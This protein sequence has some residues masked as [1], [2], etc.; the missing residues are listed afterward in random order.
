MPT[1]RPLVFVGCG[2][3]GGKTLRLARDA[4]SRRLRAIGWKG[5]VPAAWQ[6]LWIDVPLQQ[7]GGDE[8][9]SPLDPGSYY[10]LVKPGTNY[11]EG[12]DPKVIALGGIDAL[13][14]VGWRPNPAD[15]R[16]PID[17]AAGEFRAV[18]RMIAL[19]E[20]SGLKDHL[21]A[22]FARTTNGIARA[23]L[24]SLAHQ[25]GVGF[26]PRPT[27]FLVSSLAGGSGSGMFLDV[28]DMIRCLT[29]S[30]DTMIG[31]FYTADAFEDISSAGGVEPN[32]LA[33]LAELLSA[34]WQDDERRISLLRA[35][36]IP[37][38]SFTQGGP[39]FP[40]LVGSKNAAGL[41][42]SSQAEVYR[43]VGELLA[44]ITVSPEVQENLLNFGLGNWQAH[45]GANHDL[46]GIQEGGA[47]A[48]VSSIGYARMG[49][50]RDRFELYATRRLARS[51]IEFLATGY[52]AEAREASHLTPD[53]VVR[54]LCETN[55]AAFLDVC[56]LNERDEER[57]DKH[58]QVVQALVP[59]ALPNL[60]RELCE[61]IRS[62][63]VGAADADVATWVGRMEKAAET[64]QSEFSGSFDGALVETTKGWT[65][66]APERLLSASSQYV[67]RLGIP[68]TLALLESTRAS[69]TDAKNQL[70]VQGGE[71]DARATTWK[72]MVGRINLPPNNP[73][74]LDH[75]KLSEVIE[76]AA[77]PF[78]RQ[79]MAKVY[80]QAARLI[81]EFIDEVLTPLTLTLLHAQQALTSDTQRTPAGQ[82]P[83]YLEWP[84]RQEVPQWLHPSQVEFLLD[85]VDQYPGVF[86]ELVAATLPASEVQERGI[87]DPFV[88]ARQEVISGGFPAPDGSPHQLALRRPTS[89]NHPAPP[90][91]PATQTGGQGQ[92]LSFVAEFSQRDLVARAEAWVRRPGA[93]QDYLSQSLIEYLSQAKQP[94][95]STPSLEQRLVTLEAKLGAAIAAAAPLVDVDG[96]R[97]DVAHSK[98]FTTAR[99][100]EP[101]PFA[102]GHPARNLAE[103]VLQSVAGVTA[104]NVAGCFAIRD[105][106][107]IGSIGILSYVS[108]P[109][110]PV[111]LR[112]VTEPIRSRL[113]QSPQD[114]WVWRRT[115]P[116]TEFVPISGGARRAMLR[117]WYTGRLLGLIDVVSSHQP[118]RILAPEGSWLDFPH[119][120][121][122]GFTS[123]K[124]L[125][126]AGILESLPIAWL[127]W[128]GGHPQALDAY[129]CL[130]RLGLSDPDLLD[131]GYPGKL[132]LMQYDVMNPALTE[133]IQSGE[134]SSGAV[135]A[136]VSGDDEKA[137]ENAI[138]RK[139]DEFVLDIKVAFETTKLGPAHLLTAP[140]GLELMPEAMTELQ[141]VGVASCGGTPPIV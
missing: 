83:E 13:D 6:F 88:A 14:L 12:V 78:Y 7:E 59:P 15:V 43:S 23:E 1:V 117:G 65:A 84:I 42:L 53:E 71:S 21:Q 25:M 57:G 22:C 50:G 46:L 92:A 101:L 29:D 19:K 18:G 135:S 72:G 61:K 106:A 74:K 111:V 138:R 114:F 28:A 48:P 95:S 131:A 5:E 35:Q 55:I 69:L 37:N 82:G 129:R 132:T 32:S 17:R 56:G 120:P 9:G 141:R 68:V 52:R 81:E 87:S 70:M 140:R 51:A 105:T 136:L 126:V 128:A 134:V 103:K 40:F 64:L 108:D 39:A 8:F 98:S 139:C 121:L 137:R 47:P 3:S 85:D 80:R 16:I 125:P 110:H 119:P 79:S 99:V 26:Y 96:N 45:A 67:A 116:L 58:D 4:I 122:G 60:Y 20:A 115:R 112:S 27:V 118:A 113:Q 38:R 54:R 11:S 36:G 77:S 109:V 75:P 86:D 31:L 30:G 76:A 63:Q 34:Y 127:D 100:I 62:K 107:G 124:G 90:W 66:S 94:L 130:F 2:G 41:T 102:P 89:G 44:L 49:L 73:V 10:G 133:W 104:A 91:Q 123:A 93:F 33:A 24:E 97:C